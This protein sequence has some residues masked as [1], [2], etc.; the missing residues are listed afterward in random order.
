MD[1]AICPHSPSRASHASLLA[2]PPPGTLEEALLHLD[3]LRP[4]WP[5][6]DP[7]LYSE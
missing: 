7:W 4:L 3:L 2:L 5:P 6:P 1:S